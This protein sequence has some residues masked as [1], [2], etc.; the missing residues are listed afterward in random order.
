MLNPFLFN[1]H[2]FPQLSTVGRWCKSVHCRS[3]DDAWVHPRIELS[4]T[5]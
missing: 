5:R 3:F 2:L 1:C 4:P